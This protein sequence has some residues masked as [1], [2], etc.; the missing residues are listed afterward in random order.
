[1]VV[2]KFTDTDSKIDN[3][4][5]FEMVKQQYNGEY[6]FSLANLK[7]YGIIK[8]MGWAYDFR[9]ELKHYVYKQYGNWYECYAPNKTL[10]RKSTRGRINKILEIK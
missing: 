6:H 9:D 2:Y 5:N 8:L 3:T 4:I 10:L 7:K 1:M